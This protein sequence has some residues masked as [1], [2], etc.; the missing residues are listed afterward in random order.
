M[1]ANIWFWP[2]LANKWMLFPLY[3]HIA[4]LHLLVA[5]F[6]NVPLIRCSRCQ[7]Y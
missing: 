1:F 5:H 4:Y 7:A 6:T 3:I 2:N